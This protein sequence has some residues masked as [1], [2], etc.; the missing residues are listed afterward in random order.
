MSSG[1]LR[2]R[3]G[4]AGH[5]GRRGQPKEQGHGVRVRRFEEEEMEIFP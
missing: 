4:T 2:A 3:G 5:G 1:S